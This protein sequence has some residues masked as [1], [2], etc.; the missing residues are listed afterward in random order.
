MTHR[1]TLAQLR[2]APNRSPSPQIRVAIG[3]AA[4]RPVERR[5]VPC[6]QNTDAAPAAFGQTN[7]DDASP[8]MTGGGPVDVSSTAL[9]TCPVEQAL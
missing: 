7:P 2:G 4:A 3:A 8:R 1:S 9:R 5:R 6:A